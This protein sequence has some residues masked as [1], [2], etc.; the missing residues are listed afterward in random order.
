MLVF[1]CVSMQSLDKG[2]M[3][4]GDDRE[5]KSEVDR[6][7]RGRQEKKRRTSGSFLCDERK[8]IE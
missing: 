4:Q 5:L 3:T 8:K 7:V 1:V 2:K 6:E